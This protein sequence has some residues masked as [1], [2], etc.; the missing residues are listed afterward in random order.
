MA[1]PSGYIGRLGEFQQSR[2]T[3]SAYVER[4]ELFFAANNIVEIDATD[5]ESVRKNCEIQTKMRAI[6]L[7]EVGPAVYETVK[8]LLAPGKPK[9]T[10]LQVILNKLRDHF[11][12]K[13]LEIAESY[14]FGTRCQLPEEDIA[15]FVVALKKLSIHCNFG[16]FQDRALRDRFV[17]GLRS[18]R[19]RSKLMTMSNL[20]FDVACSTAIQMDLAE[21][22]SKAVRPSA[23]AQHQSS[24]E[25]HKMYHPAQKTNKA[26]ST[27]SSTG[28]SNHG[29]RTG[30]PCYRCS[31]QHSPMNCPFKNA[32]CY[33]CKKKGHIASAC[34]NKNK[35]TSKQTRSSGSTSG[36]RQSL[37]TLEQEPTTEE[38]ELAMYTISSNSTATGK[39]ARAQNGSFSVCVELGGAPVTMEIDTGASVSVIPEAVYME[40]LKQIPLDAKRI[41]LRSYS[42]EKI[43]VLGSVQ[44]P[45]TY[46]GQQADLPLVVVKGDKPAL[47]GRNWLQT[48]KLNWSD[49]FHVRVNFKCTEDVIKQH[50]KVFSAQGEQIAGHK[51]KVRVKPDAS[52]VHCK[53][54]AVPYALKEKVEKELKRLESENIISKVDN[55]E[56]ATPIVVVPKSDGSVRICGDYKVTINQVLEGNMPDTLPTAEDLFSTLTGGQV[57]TK[58]DLTNAYLQL[59]VD[60]ESKSKLTINT[61]LGLFE[62]NRLPFGIST[63]LGIFQGVMTEI[64]EGIEG[65]VCYLDDILV[66]A[67][68]KSTH[69]E[70]LLEVLKRLEKHNVRVKPQKCEFFKDSVEYLGHRVDKDGLHPMKCKVDAIKNAPTP[71]NIS[72][73][74]SFLGLVQY[75]GKFMQ[76]LATILHPLN[77]LLKNDV[78]WR[79][80]RECEE[81]FKLCKSQL[82]ES[83]MLVHYDVNKP[84]K[85]QCDASPYGVGAV[86]SHVLENGEERP[87]A[88]ASRTLSTSEGNYAQIEREALALIFGVRRFH[89]YLY[90]RRFVIETDHKPLTAILN[91]TAHVPTLAA[92]RMQ[93]WALILSAYQYDIQYRRSAEHGNADAM[94][95][96]PLASEVTPNPE[97]L[98]Y[99]SY[100]DEL[101]VTADDIRKATQTDKVLSK[102][103]EYVQNGWPNHMSNTELKPFFVRRNEL[104]IDQGCVMWGSRVIIPEKY[105]DK[106]LGDLHDQHMEVDSFTYLGSAIS[107][108]LSLDN[109]INN[110][111]GKPTAVMAKLNRRVWNNS[112]LTKNTKL[113]VYQACVLSTLL[114]GSESWATYAGS[115]PFTSVASDDSCR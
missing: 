6:F 13:P 97:D 54:R 91:P 22:G 15:N 35:P 101:P 98:F 83:T 56:W 19:I 106:L 80:T 114:Y 34:R 17:C 96:L 108:S 27:K 59:G 89:K 66:S 8:N 41:E 93:R 69:D 33:S 100:V 67:P 50:P 39:P 43:P 107:S 9:D 112:Q 104:S 115:T 11:D 92:A 45:V 88:F 79:W 38:D 86:I 87:I 26:K 40:K 85:L 18:E 109:E 76:N 74:R 49:I 3:F 42:G 4:L 84:V 81:A 82:A 75:Y 1:A 70:K 77:E 78:P 24:G 44:V 95:R 16:D 60:D 31:G 55:S 102:V 63:A 32:E 73:L 25:V 23:S 94:S 72:E 110:R 28:T 99:F 62:F 48:L 37:H 20:T 90:G 51:A 12:P 57:F 29:N 113:C 46:K 65:V 7:T 64:L 14:R 36:H 103:K 111:I 52:P 71:R 5:E 2:E 10:S 47:L 105:R 61:H 68:D 21:K 30:K 58:M 53:A